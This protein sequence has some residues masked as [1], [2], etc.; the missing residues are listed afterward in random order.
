LQ[1]RVTMLEANR[2]VRDCASPMC[3]TQRTSLRA[4]I[5]ACVCRL[6]LAALPSTECPFIQP[7]PTSLLL[8]LSQR[9][10][11]EMEDVQGAAAAADAEL[12]V[13][14]AAN[15]MTWPVTCTLRMLT[16]HPACWLAGWLLAPP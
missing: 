9:N 13:S 12:T 6:H 15:S 5:A 7:H 4:C 2:T 10:Q 14:P 16:D 3:S 1:A 8:P 11:E